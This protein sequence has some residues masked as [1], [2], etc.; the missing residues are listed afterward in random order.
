M[1][2]CASLL[3]GFEETTPLIHAWEGHHL[4]VSSGIT[5]I[6]NVNRPSLPLHLIEAIKDVLTSE[7]GHT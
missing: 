2:D 6:D 3:R 7:K 5:E 4:Q 1:K